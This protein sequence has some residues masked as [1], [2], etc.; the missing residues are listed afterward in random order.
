LLARSRK[1]ALA[2][3]DLIM[4]SHKTEAAFLWLIC[5]NQLSPFCANTQKA[6]ASK[7]A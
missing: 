2:L 7:R 5:T 4:M 6:G 3:S 1:K